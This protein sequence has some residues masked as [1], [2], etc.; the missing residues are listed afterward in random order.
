MLPWLGTPRRE[1]GA[2]MG[3]RQV[4]RR[5]F[6]GIAGGSA[7][8]LSLSSLGLRA[9][10]ARATEKVLEAWDYGTW[11]DLHRKE[12]TWDRMTFGT[13]LVDCYPG[14]CLWRVYTRDG[15]VLREEQAAIYPQVDPTG[16]DFNP[17]G[18][19]KGAFY[20]HMMY[21][22]DRLTHPMKR[23]GE[24]GSG[25]WKRIGWDEAATEVADGIL[26]A[27]EDQ[28]PESIVFECGPGNGGW[29]NVI[30]G[31]RFTSLLGGVALD[32]DATI[33][34][35]NRG[36]Y[37]TMGKFQFM[38]SVDGWF[39]GKLILI[40]HMNP[41]YTRIPSYHFIAEARY[42]GAEVVS[43]SPDYNPSAIHADE[44]IPVE[45]GADAALGLA[46][47]QVLI[48]GGRYDEAFVKEQTDLAFL[49][50]TG[51]GRFLRAS[52]LASGGREDR[53]CWWD[54]EAGRP[55]PARL[56]TLALPVDPALEGTFTV[57][58]RG[59]ATEEVRPVFALL[60]EMLDR[61][62]T[63][64]QASAACGT[65]PDTLRRLADRLWQARGHVQILVGWNT[66]KTYHGD[67]IERVMCLLLALTGSFGKKGSGI[68]GWNESLF[69]GATAQ[70]IKETKGSLAGMR[71]LVESKR[72]LNRARTE[73][74]TRTQEMLAIEL[75]REWDRRLLVNAPPAFLYY[76]HSGYR[77]V[78]NRR[79][80]HCPTMKRPFHAY[81]QEALDKG[82]WEGFTSPAEDQEPRVYFY[83]GTSPA[84]KNR[85]WAKN[86][87]PSLWKKYRLIFGMDTRWS[88][89]CLF[90]DIVLP[91]AGFYEKL[92]T[93]F[94]TPHVPWL[95]LTDRAVAPPGEAK[96]EFEIFRL[97]AGRIEERARERGL[98]TYRRRDGRKHSL[99]DLASR[100][101]LDC[102]D[103]EE[104]MEDA[105][106]GSVMMGNL[107]H[108]TD[109]AR[110]RKEG[111]VRFVGSSEFDPISLA[112][113]TDIRP[114]EPIVPL[115]HHTG[116]R[117]VP[118]PTYHL[119][120]QFYSDHPWFL[121]AGEALPVHKPNP[122]MGGEYPLRL[123]GGHQRWSVHSIW[124]T[125]EQLLRTHQGRPF[126]LINPEDA[127]RR[128][129]R[130]GDLVRLFNDFHECRIHAKLTSGAR[131]GK[132]P[133]PGQ[134]IVYHAWE[135]YQFANWL[136]YDALIPGMVKWLDLAGGYG[137]LSYY[138]WN[139][140]VQPIDRAVAVEVERA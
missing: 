5:E 83:L 96:S 117:K 21:N 3:D 54:A 72:I 71:L 49:V 38:D 118:Y 81:M 80:W 50:R 12:W 110:L 30:Q 8:L 60:R 65:H 132:G 58:L 73:D 40:W 36:I 74:P 31:Y 23:V 43:I 25:K 24:R 137:H 62:Y 20:S 95:T 138:R 105:L 22:P 46:A 122:R 52:D 121:E 124:V 32:I 108:G 10:P 44:W 33:G 2:D 13:H 136:S 79:E 107:P 48:H 26:D 34:D 104:L 131:P 113:A 93:R 123:T 17:R 68:R 37:E 67:L 15:V 78:W 55:V 39:F 99:E 18:C 119:R 102:R 28:G 6:L 111:I 69:E 139:W 7:L 87:Y 114:D 112:L 91:A 16:P 82:W 4:S 27:I 56:E 59:G 85:G 77:D 103:L 133:D 47:A 127:S 135:P 126:V 100:Q 106:Q 53:C 42:N 120:I 134:V 109:L 61:A 29:I 9:G 57:R 88:T 129:I 97:L 51:N 98:R 11:E 89:T 140:C 70:S 86:I 19:Q 84:R 101:S 76:F 35:F 64:E 41:A 116:P 75:E 125:D 90:S 1:E 14:N 128:G 66:P 94:P 92:D 115:T 45:T 63:P 130:D